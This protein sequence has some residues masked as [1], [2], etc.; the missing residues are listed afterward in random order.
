MKYWLDLFTP[1][2]WER[3]KEHGAVI[4][5]FRPRQ[6]KI[7]YQRIKTGDKLAEEIGRK[8]DVRYRKL[9]KIDWWIAFCQ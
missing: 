7:A 9:S 6:R 3:F 8:M 4:S 1:F 5:G 2:T